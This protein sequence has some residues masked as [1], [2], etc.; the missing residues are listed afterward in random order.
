MKRAQAALE[1]LTTYGW[2]ILV[3][4]IMIGALAY[5]GVINPKNL[6]KERCISTPDFQCVDHVLYTNGTLNLLLRVSIPEGVKDIAVY[7]KDQ[8]GYTATAS[9]TGDFNSDDKI[10]VSCS[11]NGASYKEG[12]IEK[13]NI[14]L[15]YTKIGGDFPH[16]VEI[17]T[18][19]RVVAS[20]SSGSGTGGGHIGLPS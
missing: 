12:D 8:D 19:N 10:M 2:A 14:A 4:T 13:V 9:S 6:I 15:N 1:F 18:I 16:S 20:S 3:V 17:Q 11:L 7:C 5:Y